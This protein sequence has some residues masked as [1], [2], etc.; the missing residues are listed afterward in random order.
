M[1]Y[2]IHAMV[3]I[4]VGIGM[5]LPVGPV[6]LA[7]VQGTVD[8]GRDFG[9]RIAAGSALAELFYCL[10]SVGLVNVLFESDT[11]RENTFFILHLVSIPLLLTLGTASLLKNKETA[12]EVRQTRNRGGYLIGLSLNLANPA[13]L[14]LWTA[15]TSFLKSHKLIIEDPASTSYFPALLTYTMGV[16]AG[17]FGIQALIAHISSKR[18]SALNEVRRRLLNRAVGIGFILFGAYQIYELFDTYKWA[19]M[20]R[21]FSG[22]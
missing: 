6:N 1:I 15:I 14:L 22:A 20:T 17:T 21:M 13:L 5:S 3:G 16:A 18:A 4:L 2:L 9:F 19:D 8:K 10:L 11:Q 12:S 7:I